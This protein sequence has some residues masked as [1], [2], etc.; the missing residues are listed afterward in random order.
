MSVAGTGDEWRARLRWWGPTCAAVVILGLLWWVWHWQFDQA[1]RE[2]ERYADNR[3]ALYTSSL[4]GALERF[5]YLP[6]LLARQPLVQAALV[7]EVGVFTEQVNAYLALVAERSGAEAIFLMNAEGL[8]LAAS[9]HGD[10][11]SF[12]G[13]NYLFRPYFIEAMA[14]GRG[15]FFAIGSTTGRAG[16]FVS[17]A[18]GGA[19]HDGDTPAGVLALKVSLE[20]LQEDWRRAG[21]KVLLSDANGVVL[22]SSRPDWRYRR[23]GEIDAKALAGIREQRQF[24]GAALE[25]LGQRLR[26]G[27]LLIGGGGVGARFLDASRGLS[28]LGWTMHY[29]VPVRPLYTRA[30]NTLLAATAVVV[31]LLLLGLWLRERQKRLRLRERETRIMRE[32]NERLE[33]RVTERT[34]ELQSAQAELVQAGKLAALGTMAAGIAHELN[35]PLA[36]IRTYAASGER[37]LERG[38]HDAAGDNFRRIQVLSERLATLIRQLKLF[39]RKGGAREPV[40]LSARIDFVVELLEERLRRQDVVLHIERSGGV[41]AEPAWIAG[42][43]VRLEQLITNLL[44]NALD[45]VRGVEAPRLDIAIEADEQRVRLWVADNGPGIDEAALEHLFDP[46]FTTKTVGDGLGLGL[47]IVYGIVQDLEGRIRAENRPREA[48]GGA[49]FCVELPR[50]YP[51]TSTPKT[52]REPLS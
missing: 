8:T 42:D 25:P 44:R 40:D 45:A 21:E 30:R 7:D 32:A 33:S 51:A 36:G 23:L 18:V 4:Q 48:G 6:E 43:E 34:R 20:S 3:L 47:F 49:C 29:L 5:T 19:R 12:I 15:E 41:S 14:G 35:Q 38:R 17:T 24:M 52:A 37:L 22:L 1:T 27:S 10:D 11:Q 16:Y 9:N 46:F 39:A 13:H 2:A 26:D 50:A 31:A 28:T